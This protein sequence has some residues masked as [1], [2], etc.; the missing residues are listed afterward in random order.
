MEVC[1]DML[2]FPDEIVER[3]EKYCHR[4]RIAIAPGPP[5]IGLEAM[6]WITEMDSVIKVHRLATTYD[7]EFDV[8]QKLAET[9]TDRLKGFAIPQLLHYDT[10]RWLW[11]FHLC[12]RRTFWTSVP[13]A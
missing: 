1:C 11:N 4:R 3:L 5:G 7:A 6:V 12:D 2:E 9:N 10:E 8:Y 13:P